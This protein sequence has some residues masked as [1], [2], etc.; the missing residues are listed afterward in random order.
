MQT[1]K[2]T[3]LINLLT[4]DLPG[5]N[6]TALAELYSIE[7]K[8]LNGSALNN[9]RDIN[10]YTLIA[11]F[12]NSCQLNN[13]ASTVY[14]YKK[15]LQDFLNHVKNMI[16]IETTY[17]Y[18]RS[19]SW[20][21]NT[22]RRNY[23]L[24]KRFLYHLFTQKHTEIDLSQH[25]KIPPKIKGSSFCPMSTQ[26][27][28]FIN[29][30]RLTFIV[31]NEILKYEILF[32]LY[33][34]TGSR[35]TELLNLNVEDIDFETGRIIIKKTK[36]K[37]VKIINMDVNLRQ[38]LIDYFNHFKYISGPLFRGSQ[39][40]RLCK[41]SLMNSF[42]KIKARAELPKEFKIHSFR[43]YFINELRKNNVD[44]ATIQKLA[45]HRDIMTTE[46]YCNVSEEEKIKAIE[47][48]KV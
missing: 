23:V 14:N 27:K 16:D 44:L 12:I 15:I 17:A 32:K 28:Q 7:Q 43:R 13:A 20:G 2:K 30:I 40:N 11:N 8:L 26:V 10:A 31:E 45:G 18:L 39:G 42:Y 35:R 47:N 5:L 33:I 36:N 41:Q 34:K 38:I 37:D 22:K 19:K 29:S 25:I 24:I 9:I 6:D 3:T 21:D 4:A 46:I 48:I 1:D